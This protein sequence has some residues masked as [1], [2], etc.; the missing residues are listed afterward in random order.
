ML[1]RGAGELPAAPAEGASWM[2]AA[3]VPSGP[4]GQLPRLAGEDL[5]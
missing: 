1:P 2:M 5:G 3:L 4:L